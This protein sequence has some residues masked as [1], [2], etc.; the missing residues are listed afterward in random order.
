MRRGTHSS[1][2]VADGLTAEHL[3]QCKHELDGCACDAV[4]LAGEP[5]QLANGLVKRCSEVNGC[6]GGKTAHR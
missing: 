5:E 6:A 1:K 3:A 2:G 4:Q